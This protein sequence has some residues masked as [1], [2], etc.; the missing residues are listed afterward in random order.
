MINYKAYMF[1]KDEV[2]KFVKNVIE[3]SKLLYLEVKLQ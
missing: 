3:L 2:I 1:F